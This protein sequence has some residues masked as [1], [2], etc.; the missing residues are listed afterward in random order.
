MMIPAFGQCF[1]GF[2]GQVGA[3]CAR[4]LAMRALSYNAHGRCVL[5]A[6]AVS[7]PQR[8][9]QLSHINEGLFCRLLM[10]VLL[11]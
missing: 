10:C 6:L 2:K 4:A 9:D 1:A 7:R 3:A 11:N 5:A 8:R